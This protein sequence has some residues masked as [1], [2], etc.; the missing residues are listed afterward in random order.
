MM[1]PSLHFEEEGWEIF[2]WE[3]RETVKKQIEMKSQIILI[4]FSYER[5]NKWFYFLAHFF[6]ISFSPCPSVA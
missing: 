6:C 2:Y 4:W 1:D 5:D 3:M